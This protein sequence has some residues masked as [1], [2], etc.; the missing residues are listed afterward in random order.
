MKKRVHPLED[1]C[2]WI[3]DS[4]QHRAPSL[5]ELNLL[6][7]GF[8]GRICRKMD[9][10]DDNLDLIPDY[11]ARAPASGKEWWFLAGALDSEAWQIGH[12]CKL[13]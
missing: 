1:G 9:V 13:R 11:C 10:L 8:M 3:Q 2:S 7:L 12:P 5:A 6:Q 4:Q